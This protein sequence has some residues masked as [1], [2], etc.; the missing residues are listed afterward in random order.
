MS[1]VILKDRLNKILG[2]GHPYDLDDV[3]RYMTIIPR[4]RGKYNAINVNLNGKEFDSLSEAFY[5][6][7]LEKLLVEGEIKSYTTFKVPAL[8]EGKYHTYYADFVVESLKGV[9]YV[10]EVKGVLTTENKVKYAYVKYVHGVNIHIVPTS[11]PGK[12]DV[13]FIR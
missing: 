13:T 12:F 4:A 8:V 2:K 3:V 1:R 5:A 11:G 7:K 6:W 9:K 10:V